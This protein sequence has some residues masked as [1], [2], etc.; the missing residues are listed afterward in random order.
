MNEAIIDDLANWLELFPNQRYLTL[1]GACYVTGS[2]FA[3]PNMLTVLANLKLR[4]TTGFPQRMFQGLLARSW[5][6]ETALWTRNRICFHLHVG[7]AGGSPSGSF[8]GRTSAFSLQRP[9]TN[10]G[11]CSSLYRTKLDQKNTYAYSFLGAYT[12]HGCPPGLATM[13]L[14]F[15]TN[16]AETSCPLVLGWVSRTDW[17]EVQSN[18]EAYSQNHGGPKITSWSTS[19]WVSMNFMFNTSPSLV[20]TVNSTVASSDAEERGPSNPFN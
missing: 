2:F 10:P 1:G 5:I 4:P 12:L 13:S 7:R 17:P 16:N 18:C 15:C 19:I 9:K 3:I 20:S 8:A 6:N 11:H 14:E